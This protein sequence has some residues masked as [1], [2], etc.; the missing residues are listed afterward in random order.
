MLAA[1]CLLFTLLLMSL[2]TAHSLSIRLNPILTLTINAGLSSRYF[3]MLPTEFHHHA[4]A[5][6]LPSRYVVR[7]LDMANPLNAVPP[8]LCFG[9]EAAK[10]SLFSN[11]ILNTTTNNS[12]FLINHC[13][14][15]SY[16]FVSLMHAIIHTTSY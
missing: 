7:L 12:L 9:M 4:C 3:L 1:F 5:T 13:V 8:C 10:S 6:P 16:T 11:R 2:I 15:L 14:F